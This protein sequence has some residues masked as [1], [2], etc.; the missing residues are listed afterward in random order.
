VAVD[1]DGWVV[2]VE[3]IA[4]QNR[5]LLGEQMGSGY[6]WL[7]ALGRCLVEPLPGG[8][9]LL[10]VED[11]PISGSLSLE[12]TTTLQIDLR[13]ATKPRMSLSGAG[14]HWSHELTPRH[15]E[16]LFVLATERS[17]PYSIRL[18]SRALRGRGPGDHSPRRDVPI[19]STPRRRDPRPA[20]PI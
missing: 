12:A 14:G 3:S 7:P 20:V 6:A 5:I 11:D 9:L 19:A 4:P 2:A 10:P 13:A 18:G 15:A 1:T 17:G 8:W 16:I